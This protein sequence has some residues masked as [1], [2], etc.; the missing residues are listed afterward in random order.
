VSRDADRQAMR[1]MRDEVASVG[2]PDAM[3]LQILARAPFSIVL[4]DPL[5]DDNPIVYVND[6]FE[7]ATGYS[8]GGAIGRNCRFLQG[9]ETD[10]ATVNRLREALRAEQEISL[11]ILNYRL[12]GSPFWNRLLIA[13]LY[14]AGD[15]LQYFLGIQKVLGDPLPEDEDDPDI[16]LR[17]IQHRVKNHLSMIVSMIRLQSRSQGATEHFETLARRVESLQLLYDE[18]SSRRGENRDAVALGAY[19]SRVASAI[20]H[21]DG[22]S[23]VRVDVDVESFTVPMETAVRIGLI[24]SEAL[25][26]ALQHAFEGRAEGLIQA[27]VHERP[28]GGIRVEVADDGIGLPEGVDLASGAGLGGR[29]VGALA[30]ALDADLRVES[31]PGGTAVTLD[32]PRAARG[33]Y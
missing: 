2:L 17:E 10:P 3:A 1:D 18:L 9:A 33:P 26:N 7:R 22:R 23:G 15:E 28:D 13:P 20:A 16:A 21:L 24:A 27:R 19:L 31:G 6:A 32:V 5:L 4:T 29:L 11:D 12:D 30:K 14:N 25:T 8:R